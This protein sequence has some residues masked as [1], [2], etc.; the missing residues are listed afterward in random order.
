MIINTNDGFV[1]MNGVEVY[2]GLNFR[3]PV[4]DAGSEI[5]NENCNSIPG[6][7]CPSGSGNQPDGMVE[8]FTHIHRGFFGIGDSNLTAVGYDWRNPF[9]IASVRA[10][11]PGP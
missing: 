7:A 10:G 8:N 11:L 1:A 9:L 5:N 4:Y 3:G 6:P 2:P